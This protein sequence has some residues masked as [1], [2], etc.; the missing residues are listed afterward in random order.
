MHSYRFDAPNELCLFLFGLGVAQSHIPGPTRALL[1]LRRHLF[2]MCGVFLSNG[3]W[4]GCQGS[5]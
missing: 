2:Q 4:R 1:Y 3:V 5:S